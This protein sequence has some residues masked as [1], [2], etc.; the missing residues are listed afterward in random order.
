MLIKKSALD[1]YLELT[2]QQLVLRRFINRLYFHKKNSINIQ[3]D[4]FTW[5]KYKDNDLEKLDEKH[6]IFGCE[7]DLDNCVEGISYPFE[8]HYMNK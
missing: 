4:K 8:N 3:L 6:E 5:L 2:K 1:K 7:Q